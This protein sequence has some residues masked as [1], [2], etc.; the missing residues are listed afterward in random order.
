M[1]SMNAAE[2]LQDA[3]HGAGMTPRDILGEIGTPW[4]IFVIGNLDGGPMRFT[5]LKRTIDG[6]SQRML[7]VSLRALEREGLVVRTVDAGKPVKVTYALTDHG[8]SFAGPAKALI[9]WATEHTKFS[10]TT[11]EAQASPPG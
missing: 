1:D 5:E 7:A 11:G 4:C 6:I 2:L 9:D 10:G 3:G 8:K